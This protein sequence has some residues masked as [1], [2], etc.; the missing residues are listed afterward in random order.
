VSRRVLVLIVAVLA[1]LTVVLI[2]A[3]LGSALG[4]AYLP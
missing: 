4:L 3:G 1:V 2:A